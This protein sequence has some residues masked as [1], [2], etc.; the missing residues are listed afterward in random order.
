M[1]MLPCRTDHY[2]ADI[3]FAS[4]F[5]G[6]PRFLQFSQSIEQAFIPALPQ[7]TPSLAGLVSAVLPEL[8]NILE[9]TRN[10][11]WIAENASQDPR[12]RNSFSNSIYRT[13]QR[14]LA[15]LAELDEDNDGKKSEKRCRNRVTGI[16]ISLFDNIVLREVKATAPMNEPPLQRLRQAL[17]E[18]EN[19]STDIWSGAEPLLLWILS[20]AGATATGRPE[21]S[22][23][24]AA[25]TQCRL[26]MGIESE[27]IFKKTLIW[28]PWV[29]NFCTHNS[30][31]L[32]EEME[33]Y[34][35]GATLG[36]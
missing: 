1:K 20:I 16:A 25:L 5:G 19:N 17:G 26:R 6:M 8:V 18:Y 32:W 10:L 35:T 3:A 13:Q 4:T 29:S 12:S 11:A 14:T 33:A 22:E 36:S 2:R 21:R 28:F 34:H 27:E 31:L 24:I 9:T 30:T 15:I 7:E 23:A